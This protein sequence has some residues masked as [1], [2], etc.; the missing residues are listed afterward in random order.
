MSL[1]GNTD[2]VTALNIHVINLN[3]SRIRV[4]LIDDVDDDDI[5]NN[6]IIIYLCTD[7]T[8]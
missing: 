1:E 8:A 6:S 2:N 7:I 5:N 4:G 3:N